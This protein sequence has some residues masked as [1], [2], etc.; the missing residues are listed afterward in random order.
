MEVKSFPHMV[1]AS[2][3]LGDIFIL[4]LLCNRNGNNVWWALLWEPACVWNV[5]N[6][7]RAIGSTNTGH[8]RGRGVQSMTGESFVCPQNLFHGEETK[9]WEWDIYLPRH[10]GTLCSKTCYFDANSK[11]QHA[12]IQKVSTEMIQ[13]VLLKHLNKA[14][15]GLFSLFKLPSLLKALL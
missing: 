2:L 9:E 10:F 6:Y 12:L 4:A 11:S 15:P 3:S 5:L 13:F 7:F 1:P 14:L 8:K